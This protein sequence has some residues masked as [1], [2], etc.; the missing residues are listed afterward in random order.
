MALSS[1]LSTCTI[2]KSAKVVEHSNRS[3][4]DYT[5]TERLSIHL[6]DIARRA[7]RPAALAFA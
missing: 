5:K 6:F 1:S 3:R 2:K 4:V 7:F